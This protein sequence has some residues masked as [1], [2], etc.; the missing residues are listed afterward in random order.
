LEVLDFNLSVGDIILGVSLDFFVLRHR[1]LDFNPKGQ[2]FVS[3]NKT[4]RKSASL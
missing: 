2:F 4:R 3:L 1:A